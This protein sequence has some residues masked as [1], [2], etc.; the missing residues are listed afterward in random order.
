MLIQHVYHTQGCQRNNQQHIHYHEF[1]CFV[2]LKL[3]QQLEVVF[4]LAFF[5]NIFSD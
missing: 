1:A 4:E 5:A 3:L 2:C